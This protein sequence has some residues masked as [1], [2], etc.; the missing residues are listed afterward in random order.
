MTKIKGLVSMF[1]ISIFFIYIC[2]NKK[3]AYAWNR[4]MID[5]LTAGY[6]TI[7]LQRQVPTRT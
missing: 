7:E 6:S 1:E 5:R 2:I 4:T 3:D